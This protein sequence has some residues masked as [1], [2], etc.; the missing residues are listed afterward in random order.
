MYSRF[1]DKNHYGFLSKVISNDFA[2]WVGNRLGW[3][4]M[5]EGAK[6]LGTSEFS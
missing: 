5:V 6:P 2:D 1:F 4:R 3:F